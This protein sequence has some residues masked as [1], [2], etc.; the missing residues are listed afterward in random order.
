VHAVPHDTKDDVVEKFLSKILPGSGTVFR[1]GPSDDNSYDRSARLPADE[2]QPTDTRQTAKRAPAAN[3]T[4]YPSP[5]DTTTRHEQRQTF[6]VAQRKRKV[7]KMVP[8][9][10][11]KNENDRVPMRQICFH[12]S[13]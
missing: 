8:M 4:T 11:A 12:V 7:C 3:A 10:R 6:R 13:V 5:V 9:E 2:P 1:S